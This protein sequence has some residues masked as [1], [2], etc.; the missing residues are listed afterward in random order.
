MCKPSQTE[1]AWTNITNT[2]SAKQVEDIRVKQMHYMD[3]KQR[4]ES[5]TICRKNENMIQLY[6]EYGSYSTGIHHHS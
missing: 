2:P 4:D 1:M 3:D 5:I 6:K